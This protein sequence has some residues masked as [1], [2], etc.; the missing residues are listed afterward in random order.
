VTA[1]H[2][3]KH[4]LRAAFV[5]VLFAVVLAAA[6]MTFGNAILGRYLSDGLAEGLRLDEEQASVVIAEALRE[7]PEIA[8]DPWDDN[9]D[10]YTF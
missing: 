2:L 10:L 9:T 3:D 5:A 7:A 4:P 8:T 6:T 1:K